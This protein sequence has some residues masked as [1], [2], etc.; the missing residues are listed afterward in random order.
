M[1]NCKVIE[2]LNNLIYTF[3]KNKDHANLIAARNVKSDFIYEA[4]KSSKSSIEILAKL[5]KS[6]EEAA[7]MYKGINKE[8]YDNEIREMNIIY[9]ILPTPIG[10]K[11]IFAYFDTLTLE[12]I[13]SNFRQFQNA[14][15]KKFG[16]NIDSKIILKYITK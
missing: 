9:P 14:A 3:L 5:Y 1:E 11:E 4:E 16:R 15:A 2:T 12:H 6:R 13:K 7:L 8:L 10:E